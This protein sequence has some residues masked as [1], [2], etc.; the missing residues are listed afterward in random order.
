[1]TLWDITLGI[2][3]VR[4]NEIQPDNF[5]ASTVRQT[6][7]MKSVFSKAW[8]Q[9]WTNAAVIVALLVIMAV[10]GCSKKQPAATTVQ[11]DA[12]PTNP[13]A[14]PVYNRPATPVVV[15][16]ATPGEPDLKQM[17]HSL[18]SWI[19]RT[20]IVPKSFEDFVAQANIQ[21]SP[22]PPGKKY[23]IGKRMVIELAKQ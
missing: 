21:F 17:T 10:S 3:C 18:R 23:V 14:A 12:P 5:T 7:N 15:A 9:I 13:A 2:G 19:A 22:P 4:L 11:A 16:S 1:M 6:I 20:H 8:F